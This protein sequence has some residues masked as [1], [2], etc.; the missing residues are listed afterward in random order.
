[1]NLYTYADFVR[2]HPPEIVGKFLLAWNKQQ[3]GILVD[4]AHDNRGLS[5]FVYSAFSWCDTPDGHVFW[6]SVARGNYRLSAP[7]TRKE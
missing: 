3:P 1:M 6:E 4:T 5:G 7:L 2:E